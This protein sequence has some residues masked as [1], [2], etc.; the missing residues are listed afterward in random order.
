MSVCLATVAILTRGV[1]GRSQEEAWGL[2]GEKRSKVDNSALRFS[3]RLLLKCGPEAAKKRIRTA[4]P[5]SPP[6]GCGVGVLAY[7]SLQL[8]S[9]LPGLQESSLSGTVK[10]NENKI[11]TKQVWSPWGAKVLT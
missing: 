3:Y 11:R 2:A 10:T 9:T 6:P 4:S 8:G 1:L 7:A 5:V